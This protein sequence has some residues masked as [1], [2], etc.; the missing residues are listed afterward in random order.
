MNDAISPPPTRQEAVLMAA[1]ACFNVQGV[2]AGS[3][4]EI[5]RRAAASV[6]SVY[7]HYGSKEGLAAAVYCEGLRRFQLGYRAVLEGLDDA[8]AGIVALVRFHMRWVVEH[9]D[10]A[11]YLLRTRSDALQPQAQAQV[12][13]LNAD[14]YQAMAA[15]FAPHVASGALRVLPAGLYGA[16]LVGPVQEWAR[17]QLRT[18]APQWDEAVAGALADAIW[19]ALKN[20]SS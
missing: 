20:P 18:D 3:V 10:W 5:C 13:A 15:W 2:E 1:L 19:C 9:P 12:A 14:F 11:R 7:H 6:G 4:A 8:H 17:G 16:V